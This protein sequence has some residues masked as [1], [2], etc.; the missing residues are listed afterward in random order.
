MHRTPFAGA[1]HVKVNRN[2]HLATP[3]S[4]VGLFHVRCQP[5]VEQAVTA[6]DSA[7]TI[8]LLDDISDHVRRHI[9]VAFFASFCK[10]VD[11][12]IVCVVQLCQV[13]DS[14][15][16]CRNV[17]SVPEWRQQALQAVMVVASKRILIAFR[18]VT[19]LPVAFRFMC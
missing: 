13:Y 19:L 9:H 4:N 16:F 1:S 12:K 6:P 8:Q 7:N 14:A 18:P 11:I 3:P 10:P 17:H 2:Q 15:E 5:I